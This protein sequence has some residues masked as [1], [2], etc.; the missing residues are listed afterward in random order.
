MTSTGPESRRTPTRQSSN[1]PGTAEQ[2]FVEAA[3]RLFAQKGFKGT[4]I[5]DLARELNL[6]TA[7]LYY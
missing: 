6:T 5:S 3:T 4:S 7:S 2:A 1:T